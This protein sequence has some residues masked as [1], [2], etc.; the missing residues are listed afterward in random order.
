MKLLKD[1]RFLKISF[2]FKFRIHP[3]SIFLKLIRRL[4]HKSKNNQG[5][6]AILEYEKWISRL[7]FPIK[8]EQNL[9]ELT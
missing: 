2:F 7:Y 6:K 1:I 3:T 9:F 5:F 4:Y 8:E